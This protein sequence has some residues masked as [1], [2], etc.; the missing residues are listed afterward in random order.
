MF[1]LS[2]VRRGNGFTVL[3]LLIV[4]ALVLVLA[5][6]AIRPL[7]TSVG[8]SIAQLDP[9]D[10]A[11]RSLKWGN[12]V[13]NPPDRIAYKQTITV[14]AVMSRGVTVDQLTEE[15]RK[16]VGSGSAT[17]SR[18]LQL[19]D[20]V[21]TRLTP[22]DEGLVV[23]PLTD[24]R[25]PVGT[26]TST[27]WRWRV[28]ANRGG[29]RVLH[30]TVDAEVL[31]DGDRVPKTVQ[32]LDQEIDVQV[33]VARRI[34]DFTVDHWEWLG[35]SIVLPLGIYFWRKRKPAANLPE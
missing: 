2:S 31:V 3:E 28:T 15:L 19:S 16:S 12:V 17:T 27:E 10:R 24:E 4:A 8:R 9:I 6:I 23:V 32:T 21:R 35:G 29:K 25:Q 22:D 30:L 7:G 5:A 13:F 14:G 20:V 11:L 34:G 33:T 26:E 1:S 18:K